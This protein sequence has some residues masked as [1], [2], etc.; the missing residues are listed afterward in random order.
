MK[1]LGAFFSKLIDK[2]DIKKLMICAFIVLSLMLVPKIDILSSLMPLDDAEKVIKFIFVFIAIYIILTIL[3]YIWQKVVYYF[4]N[5]PKK[6]FWLMG[7]YGGYINIFYSEEINEYSASYINLREYNISD[8]IINKLLE[9]KIIESS[10]LDYYK[11]RL[12]KRARKKLTRMKKT[13][14]FI[15]SKI[16]NRKKQREDNN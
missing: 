15:D 16:I 10:F 11:C 4:K 1:D 13:V 12:T 5:K 8:D 3:V 9:H 2:F 7:E 14:M 6:L